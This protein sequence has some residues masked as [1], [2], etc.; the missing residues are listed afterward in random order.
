VGIEM[1]GWVSSMLLVLTIGNQIYKPWQEE[2]GETAVCGR[3]TRDD[4]QLASD[5]C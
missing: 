4:S 5:T 1:I 3:H 2:S